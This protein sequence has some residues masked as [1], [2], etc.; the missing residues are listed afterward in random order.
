[1]FGDDPFHLTGTENVPDWMKEYFDKQ[2]KFIYN[3]F[4]SDILEAKNGYTEIF[5]SSGKYPRKLRQE[6]KK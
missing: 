5:F 3:K 6:T 4:M 2:G 1:V